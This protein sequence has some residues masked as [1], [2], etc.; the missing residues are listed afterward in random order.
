MRTTVDLDPYL[1][2]R[3]RDEAHRRGVSFKDMLAAAI[4]RG[5]GDRPVSK[6]ARYRVPTHD[7][8]VPLRSVEKATAVAAGLEDDEILRKIAMRK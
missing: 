5:L 2:K 4:S 3:L 7:M 8:G 6:R 1:L